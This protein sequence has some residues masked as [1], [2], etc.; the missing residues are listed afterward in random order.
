MSQ[1][2]KKEIITELDTISIRGLKE[3]EEL[4]EKNHT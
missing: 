1:L 4:R 2:S 3:R